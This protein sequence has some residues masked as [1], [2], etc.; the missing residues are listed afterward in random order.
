MTIDI[1]NKLH[2]GFWNG[3]NSNDVRDLTKSISEVID[4]TKISVFSHE[5]FG[6]VSIEVIVEND[7][8]LSKIFI[9]LSK[10]WNVM[11]RDNFMYLDK[12][13]FKYG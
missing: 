13:N 5:E 9:K 4:M 3:F 7:E 2:I 8:E 10:Y 1:T 12:G 6:T 11:L